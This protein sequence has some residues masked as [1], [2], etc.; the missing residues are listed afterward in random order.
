VGTSSI[1]RMAVS[2]GYLYDRRLAEAAETPTSSEGF[3]MTSDNC[4]GRPVGWLRSSLNFRRWTAEKLITSSVYE[5]LL[6]AMADHRA[7]T[8]QGS[9]Q[10][11][12]ANGEQETGGEGASGHEGPL[13]LTE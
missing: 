4:V 10:D 11:Q 12:E 8:L 5:T 1:P 2:L 9:N 3:Q 7:M 13:W 6:S